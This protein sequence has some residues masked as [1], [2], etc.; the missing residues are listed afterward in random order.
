[1]MRKCHVE[2]LTLETITSIILIPYVRMF[3]ISTAYD[4]LNNSKLFYILTQR[5][6][7]SYRPPENYSPCLFFIDLRSFSMF[8]QIPF[9]NK[10]AEASNLTLTL[11]LPP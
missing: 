5:S 2:F 1:M 6:V 8:I 10:N 7:W 3:E 4:L 11:T 9:H